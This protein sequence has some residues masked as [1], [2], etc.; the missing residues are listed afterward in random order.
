MRLFVSVSLWSKCEQILTH[1]GVYSTVSVTVVP[2]KT[3]YQKE[4]NKI[5]QRLPFFVGKIGGR[6]FTP[7]P[8]L[9][10]TLQGDCYLKII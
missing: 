9:H 7:H 6:V 8:T 3:I 1:N 5:L 4:T 10:D 2:S